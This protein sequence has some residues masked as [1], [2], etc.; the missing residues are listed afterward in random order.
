LPAWVWLAGDTQRV[1][2]VVVVGVGVLLA[3]VTVFPRLLIPD[4]SASELAQL[5]DGKERLEALERRRELQN[6]IAERFGHAIEEHGGT[7]MESRLGGIYGL[8][9]IAKQE[10]SQRGVV[11]EVLVA[12]VRSHA[13]KMPAPETQSERLTVGEELRDRFPDVQAA[14]TVL[15]RGQLFIEFYQQGFSF[16]FARLDLRRADLRQGLGKVRACLVSDGRVRGPGG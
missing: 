6:N 3:C 7:S 12:Y 2:L 15:S 13:P 8:E 16:N 14:L 11:A 4:A 9:L 10:P 5:P 1:V